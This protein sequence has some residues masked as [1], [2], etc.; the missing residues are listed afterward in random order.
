MNLVDQK[1]TGSGTGD[2]LVA[3]VAVVLGIP[4]DD[5]LDA[6]REAIYRGDGTWFSV[7][8]GF[9][10]GLG[11]RVRHDCDASLVPADSLSIAGGPSPRECAAG[12]AVVHR[13][14]F[15]PVHDPHPS[16]AFL[17]GRPKDWMW[18]D[19]ISRPECVS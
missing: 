6:L 7:L 3:C 11:F 16:R 13:G 4:Y 19:P 12:H 9:A 18:F 15:T 1:I 2:C 5:R 17:A 14:P 8:E 10:L